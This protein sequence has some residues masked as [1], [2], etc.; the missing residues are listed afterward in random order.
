M[1]SHCGERG[2]PV[3][4]TGN[5]AA[6]SGFS[7]S[8]KSASS[9]L[10]WAYR[11]V[12][13]RGLNR[14]AARIHEALSWLMNAT[15]SRPMPAGRAAGGGNPSRWK[16]SLRSAVSSRCATT[17]RTR[18][19]PAMVGRS[20]SSPSSVRSRST[21]SPHSGRK[22]GRVS[23]TGSGIRILGVNGDRDESVYLAATSTRPEESRRP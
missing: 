14:S 15:R 20:E 18:Q 7:V 9:V 17:S 19:L 3:H 4:D 13:T 5:I 16:E 8:T 6:A 2:S 23:V 1:S 22:R 21:I 10:A 12:S 11:S